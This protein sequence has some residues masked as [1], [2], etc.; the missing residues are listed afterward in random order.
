[1]QVACE[2]LTIREARGPSFAWAQ[3]PFAPLSLTPEITRFVLRRRFMGLLVDGVWQDQWYDTAS[4]GGRFVRT[5]TRYRN[6][7]TADGSAG[8]SGEGGFAA[9]RGRYHLYVS[10]A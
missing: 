4:T 3:S 1:M 8:P 10:L 6:W 7:V 5:T 9:E 2:A